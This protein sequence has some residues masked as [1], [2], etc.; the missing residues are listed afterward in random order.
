MIVSNYQNYHAPK[1]KQFRATI[2]YDYFTWRQD[3]GWSR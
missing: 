3:I 1:I 2:L